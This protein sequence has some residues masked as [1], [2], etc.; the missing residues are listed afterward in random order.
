MSDLVGNPEDRFSHN[1]SHVVSVAVS[2]MVGNRKT[3][4]VVTRF[5]YFRDNKNEPELTDVKIQGNS[6]AI[7]SPSSPAH[8]VSLRPLAYQ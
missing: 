7:Q 3:G 4:F 5:L 6:T 1:E 2:Y 8:K